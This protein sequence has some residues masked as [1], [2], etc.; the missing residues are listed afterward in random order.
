[1]KSRTVLQ[2]LFN[3][4]THDARV[5]KECASLVK[6]GFDVHV[7]C[8]A[9]TG[10]PT[11]EER[12]GVKIRRFSFLLQGTRPFRGRGHWMYAECYLR[13]LIASLELRP[14]WVQAND[15]EALP[16]GYLITRLAGGRLLYDSHELWRDCGFLGNWPGWARRAVSTMEGFLGGKADQVVTVSEGIARELRAQYGIQLPLVIRNVPPPSSL[17]VPFPGIKERLGL[18][19][20]TRLIV[21]SG[22]LQTDR[23]LDILLKA[24]ATLPPSIHLA[25]LG[26]GD[27]RDAFLSASSSLDLSNR[28]HIIPSVTPEMVPDMLRGA[29]LAICPQVNLCLNHA[30]CLPN[31]LFEALHANVPVV[32]ANLPEMGGLVQALGVGWTFEPGSADDLARVIVE[33]FTDPLELAERASA[34]IKACKLLSWDREVLPYLASFT[35]ED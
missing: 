26:V 13:M 19:T 6:A 12:E 31:K 3:P 33:A 21:H 32:V 18:C 23:G 24:M 5:S 4:F 29:D 27:G 2:L 34:T 17:Q 30:F 16:L 35:L 20:K 15:L 1:M 7:F 9:H 22:N 14:M 28:V 25:V 11:Q 10:L 8:L